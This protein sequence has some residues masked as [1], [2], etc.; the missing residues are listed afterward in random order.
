ME[1]FANKLPHPYLR[2]D[3]FL[4]TKKPFANKFLARNNHQ[5]WKAS[6]YQE[7]GTKRQ[8]RASLKLT[9]QQVANT[10]WEVYSRTTRTRFSRNKHKLVNNE[11]ARTLT[12]KYLPLSFSGIQFCILWSFENRRHRRDD[13]RENS[14]WTQGVSGFAGKI[15]L[16]F[17]CAMAF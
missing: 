15:I 6:C 12:R 11:Q 13:T 3:P 9:R 10:L 7:R 14:Q 17:H 2:N 5:E 4:S 8:K 1:N 16:P